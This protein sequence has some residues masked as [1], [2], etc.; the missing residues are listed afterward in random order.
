MQEAPTRQKTERKIWEELLKDYKQPGNADEGVSLA[1]FANQL[2]GLH[3]QELEEFAQTVP[4]TGEK[5]ISADTVSMLNDKYY[6][7][8]LTLNVPFRNM[9]D[10]LSKEIEERVPLRYRWFACALER[11]PFHWKDPSAIREEM[12]LHALHDDYI[13]TVLA[14]IKAHTYHVKRYLSGEL[15]VDDVVSSDDNNAGEGEFPKMKFSRR[16]QY[17]GQQ[18]DKQMELVIKATEAEN[19]EEY[20]AATSDEVT[21]NMRPLAPMGPPGTEKTAVII[22]KLRK[23]KRKG[24]RILATAPTA[25]LASRMRALLPDVEVDTCAG[26]FLFHREL[27]EALPIM[28]QYDL[29]VVDEI[30][31]LSE[32]NFDRIMALWHAAGKMVCLI[33]G[34]DLWQMPGPHKPPSKVTDSAAWKL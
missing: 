33:L 10:L 19:D 9:E 16:Q 18:I 34:G 1:T 7:Q 27:S 31:M 2:Y 29:I 6:G 17:L 13:E 23:W 20:E 4:T 5:L 26:G 22:H 14:K 30:S 11:A 28:T 24:A 15:K 8:W 3:V 32:S 12:M 21:R 25:N